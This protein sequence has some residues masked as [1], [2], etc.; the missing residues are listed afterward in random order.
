MPKPAPVKY[1]P[2]REELIE[3]LAKIAARLAGFDP[4]GDMR[5]A[6]GGDTMFEGPTWRKP[7]FMDKAARALNVLSAGTGDQI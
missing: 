6:V 2:T 1:G 7:A 3:Q 4:E 5:E